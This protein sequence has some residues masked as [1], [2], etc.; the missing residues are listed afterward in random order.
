MSVSK[1]DAERRVGSNPTP[2]TIYQPS[3]FDADLFF[4]PHGLY[5][6]GSHG[7]RRQ[8][9]KKAFVKPNTLADQ[10]GTEGTTLHPNPSN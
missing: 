1:T 3:P 6:I 9:E 10:T 4:C 7:I 2:G 8:G 5:G